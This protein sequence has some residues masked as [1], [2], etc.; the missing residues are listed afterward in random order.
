MIASMA[1]MQ[2]VEQG[3]IDLDVPAEKYLPELGQVKL[4]DGSSPKTKITMRHLLTH[5]AGF[6]YTFFNKKLNE[7]YEKS[8]KDEFDGSKEG[9]FG[10]PLVREPGTEWE[11]S[12]AIDCK[13]VGLYPDGFAD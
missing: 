9:T 11:Y 3:K 4:V 12:T 13:S 6:G 7:H 10:L 8:G 1:C 5:T 2:L